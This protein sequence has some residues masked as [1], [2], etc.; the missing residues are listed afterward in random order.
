V[1]ELLTKHGRERD[2][3]YNPDLSNRENFR[4]VPGCPHPVAAATRRARVLFAAHNLSA[5][6]GA[7][8]Y[9]FDIAAGLKQRGRIEPLV[10]SPMAGPGDAWYRRHAIP[11]HVGNLPYARNFLEAKWKQL[12]YAVTMDRLSSLLDEIQP[13]VVVA[14][15]L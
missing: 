7:P 3:C 11:V 9:L 10:F 5:T 14:N 12:E 2:P 6:E 13:D 4:V 1:R 8:R 15:T